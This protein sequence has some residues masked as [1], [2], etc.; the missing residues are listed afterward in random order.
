MLSLKTVPFEIVGKWMW[1]FQKKS[2]CFE[3]P[4]ENAQFIGAY[5]DSEIV[6]YFI[7]QG[8]ENRE[9]EINQGYLKAQYRHSNLPQGFMSLL[10]EGLRQ[11]GYK[12]VLLGTHNRFR[13]YLKFAK[14]LGYKPEHLVFSKNLGE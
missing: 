2:K 4:P 13:S 3:M 7:I 10:E 6:G 9:V 5:K 14:L 11:D 1:E 8:Y 12:K